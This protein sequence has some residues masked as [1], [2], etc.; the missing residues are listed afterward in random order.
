MSSHPS[1]PES[2]RK[3]RKHEELELTIDKVVYGGE[4]LATH[5]GFKIFVEGTAPQ[6]SVLARVKKVRGSYAEAQVVELLKPSPQRC[7]TRCQHAA[8]CGGCKWQFLPYET[9]LATKQTHV[10]DSLER[11][12]NL[13]GDLVLPILGC[14]EP[15]FYRNK[16]ELSFGKSPEGEA[17]LGFFPSGYHYEVF[18]LQECFLQSPRLAEIAARVRTFANAHHLS[19][20]DGRTQEG[21]LRSLVIREAK[22]TADLMI[23]LNT[24]TALFEFQE[25]FAAL[26]DDLSVSSVY[27]NSVYQIPGQPTWIEENLL[28][29]KATLTEALILENGARLEFDVLP[30]AF[31][32]TNTKQAEVLYAQVLELAELTGQET[33]FDLYCG[34]GSIGLFCAHRAKSVVGVEVNESAVDNARANAQRNGIKN[35]QFF[36][37]RVEDR[38]LGLKNS[39]ERPDVVIVDPPRA[40]LGADVVQALSE[41]EAPRLIYVSCNPTTLARDLKEFKQVGYETRSV[42]PVDMFPQTYHIECVCLLEKAPVHG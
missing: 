32:Q 18:D 25:A 2:F 35:A 41:F 40:G 38:L 4:G 28:K 3:P 34:T 8:V 20:F 13:P 14:S 21:L 27:W 36:L 31:F 33:L 7:A 19:V 6:D 42:R 5:N 39:A 15:W 16:M 29:G 1:N 22:N 10:R 9:Q 26:F 11:I 23:I 37:G 30:Q 17:M 12:G 24:S